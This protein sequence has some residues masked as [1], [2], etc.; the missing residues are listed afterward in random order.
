MVTHDPLAA[1]YSKRVVFLKDGQV[2][3]HLERTAKQRAFFQ[4]ILDVL[5]RLEGNYE[6][7]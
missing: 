7:A 5:A 4:H 2:F 1:S 3:T 6:L